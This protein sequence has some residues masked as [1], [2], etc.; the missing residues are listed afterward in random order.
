MMTNW[1][2][3]WPFSCN[4]LSNIWFELTQQII[5]SKLKNLDYKWS[6]TVHLNMNSHIFDRVSA[7]IQSKRTIL[8][9]SWKSN[10]LPCQWETG[11]P[12]PCWCVHCCRRNWGTWQL[13]EARLYSWAP[14]THWTWFTH[15]SWSTHLKSSKSSFLEL[16]VLKL[17]P[18]VQSLRNNLSKFRCFRWHY[19]K[20]S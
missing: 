18:K 10:S 9:K 20:I 13:T 4:Y 15:Q 7:E 1:Q 16:D 11:R 12:V 2:L 5:C 14:S 17:L 6:R 3:N 8:S 19:Y